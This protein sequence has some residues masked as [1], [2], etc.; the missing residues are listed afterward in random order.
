MVTP[1]ETASQTASPTSTPTATPTATR[2]PEGG[3]CMQNVECQLGL[4]CVDD[5]GTRV[6]ATPPTSNTNLLIGLRR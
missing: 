3:A 4:A 6:T 5:V 2:V 1:T